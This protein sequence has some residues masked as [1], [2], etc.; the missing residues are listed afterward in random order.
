MSLRTLQMSLRMSLRVSLLLLAAGLFLSANSLRANDRENA[1]SFG[2]TKREVQYFSPYDA[3]QKRI[4]AS[5]VWNVDPSQPITRIE[6]NLTQCTLAGYQGDKLVASTIVSPGKDGHDTPLGTFPVLAKDKDH[7]STE[8]GSFVD[9]AD[10]HTVDYGA[11]A[12][13]AAPSGAHY[14]PAPMSFFLR[15][16]DDG[17]GLHAGFVTGTRVSHGCIRLPPTFAE[18][19]FQVVSVGTPVTITH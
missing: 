8:Y 1:V 11:V 13:A 4:D 17:V 16:T 3:L 14:E 10:G 5:I 18:N 2:G 6:I 19:L 9:N 7:K 15:L 12:G